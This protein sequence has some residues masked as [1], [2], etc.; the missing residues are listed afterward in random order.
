MSLRLFCSDETAPV[1]RAVV[2]E[3]RCDGDHGLFPPDAARFEQHGFIAQ[4]AAA[5]KAGWLDRQDSVLCPQCSGKQK[6]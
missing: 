5:M 2:L 6:V 1:P 4:Y 3:M